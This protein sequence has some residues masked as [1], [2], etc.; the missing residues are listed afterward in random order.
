MKLT[1][2]LTK[3]LFVPLF[4]LILWLS[5]MIRYIKA[6]NLGF[7]TL[8]IRGG[9]DQLKGIPPRNELFKGDIVSG[10]FFDR[11]P[12]LG[13]IGIRF[14]NQNRINKDRL[15]FRLKE[16]GSDNWYY[17]AQYNTD[18]FQLDSIFP[19]GFPPIKGSAKKR[20]YLEIESLF[21]ATDSAIAIIN[22][23]PVFIGRHTFQKE[24][25]LKDKGLLL[26]FIP[27]KIINLLSLPEF[28][29][30][31]FVYS[32][33][34]VFYS[35]FLLFGFSFHFPVFVVFVFLFI[36][37]FFI[38]TINDFLIVAVIF[39][40]TLPT[41]KF[42]FES[43]ISCSLALGLFFIFPLFF[44]L[45]LVN[46]AEKFAVWGYLF[47]TLAIVQRI[48]EEHSHP[49]GLITYKEFWRSLR[50]QWGNVLLFTYLIAIGEITISVK[51]IK[52][53]G[54]LLAKSSK[55]LASSGSVLVIKPSKDLSPSGTE[56]ISLML[57]R[58]GKP[59]MGVYIYTTKVFSIFI[60]IVAHI[61]RL[62]IRTGPY[63]LLVYLIRLQILNFFKYLHIYQDFFVSSQNLLF[64]DQIG[65][66]LYGLFSLLFVIFIVLQ[67]KRSLRIKTL[68]ASVLLII[69]INVAQT[70]FNLKAARFEYR[71]TIW[72]VRPIETAEPW[73]DVTVEGRNFNEMPFRGKVLVNRVEQRIIKWSDREIVF[74][75]D[76][77]IT[78]SGKLEV[79]TIDEKESNQTNFRYTGN[80]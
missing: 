69:S 68:L 3:H 53:G 73:V 37:I 75:T 80:R 11:Y 25:L 15:E 46:I 12:N 26:Y 13:I 40:W 79:V 32:L 56:L 6:E 47:F 66:L 45:G 1:K 54:V 31:F 64:Q 67:R 33:P 28:R 35:L 36:D 51:A 65:H 7:L 70:I 78:R 72:S 14:S 77:N 61:L 71:V 62:I 57:Y 23:P 50:V 76:P 24:A 30:H 19:I 22:K 74:R 39:A 48:Y 21:G 44:A 41:K 59:M 18:Q 20:Y 9:Y 38:K 55:E 52:E 34:L 58:L 27:S 49:E 29:F 17:K 43:E 60:Y 8:D 16:A 4:L 42:R 63:L 10:E 2:K 5:L